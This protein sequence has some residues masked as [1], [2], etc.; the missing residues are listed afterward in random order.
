M[1]DNGRITNSM[2]KESILKKIILPIRVTLQMENT[3]ALELWSTKMEINMKVNFKMGKNMEMV[4][5]HGKMGITMTDNGK[6][7]ALMGMELP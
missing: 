1:M 2:V 5:I 6:T 4:S 7:T 3:M